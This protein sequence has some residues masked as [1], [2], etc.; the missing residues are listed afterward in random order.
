[1][2]RYDNVYILGHPI[3]LFLSGPVRSTFWS[4][5]KFYQEISL[6]ARK[7]WFP[8]QM[9]IHTTVPRVLGVWKIYFCQNKQSLG[10]RDTSFDLLRFSNVGKQNRI[11]RGSLELGLFVL[12]KT[13]LDHKSTYIVMFYHLYNVGTRRSN[14][15]IFGGIYKT[16]RFSLKYIFN[17]KQPSIQLKWRPLALPVVFVVNIPSVWKNMIRMIIY[18][19]IIEMP[20]NLEIKC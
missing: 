3:V 4:L 13:V 17:L 5:I 18:D 20:D 15:R 16:F 11:W 7:A 6:Y 10:V 19:D 12:F 1:M 14:T 9:E 2:S 8:L